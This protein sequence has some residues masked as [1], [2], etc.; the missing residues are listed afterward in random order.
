M[1]I[2]VSTLVHH[3]QQSNVINFCS[4]IFVTVCIIL[5]VINSYMSKDT[6]WLWNYCFFRLYIASITNNFVPYGISFDLYM[7]YDTQRIYAKQ[8][9]VLAT[10]NKLSILIEYWK[11]LNM[12]GTQYV[13]QIYYSLYCNNSR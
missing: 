3:K 1:F 13:F 6:Q 5:Y 9:K 10:I 2:F 8:F 12:H 11:L 4:C 7:A